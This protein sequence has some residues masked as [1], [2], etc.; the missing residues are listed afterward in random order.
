M[1]PELFFSP[2]SE[3]IYQDIKEYRSFYKSI[4][5]FETK[6]PK[7]EDVDIALIGV[8]EHRGSTGNEGIAN[9]AD[10]IR[11]KLYRLKKG[12]GR[13]K[14][15]DLGNLNNGMDATDTCNRLR[16]V[17]EWLIEKNILP[18]VFGGSHDMDMGQYFSY[19]KM[20]KLINVLTIDAFMD[21]EDSA[22]SPLNKS[23]TQKIILHDP[24][25][26]FHYCHL[27]Y[28]TYLTDPVAIELMHKMYFELHRIG[29]M[30][31]NLAEIEPAIRDADMMSFDLTAIKSSDAPG[32]LDA[33]PFGLTGEEACQICWYAGQNE[34]MSSA[35]FYEYNPFLDDEN[36]KTASVAATMIWYF[37]EGYYN[38]KDHQNYKSNDYLKYV[39]SM[40]SEPATLT[41]YKSK[42]SEKWWMETPTQLPGSKYD[43]NVIIPCSYSDYQTA[44]KGEM[45]DRYIQA[46]T[47]YY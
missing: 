34:K 29:E 30:R 16:E 18:V 36:L 2:V 23:H 22:D 17:C 8:T 11:K 24:N 27:A 32:T 7:L 25:Y 43:R 14:V 3:I 9:G 5:A 1:N 20:E 13:Y 44:T 40:P 37:I 35:G 46:Q 19:E 45:P 15:A 33:Q 10:E 28:Q 39:V 21:L 47:K 26:L 38:R 4:K 12:A 31:Q 42:L 6:M 41:F